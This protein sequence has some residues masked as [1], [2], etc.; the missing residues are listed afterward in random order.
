MNV[1]VIDPG[2]R[3]SAR[4]HSSTSPP[5]AWQQVVDFCH[6]FIPE[7]ARYAPDRG[8]LLSYHDIL[9]LTTHPISDDV[10]KGYRALS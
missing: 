9:I 6:N 2:S 10:G 1:L 8:M 7:Q 4:L 5:P 3:R